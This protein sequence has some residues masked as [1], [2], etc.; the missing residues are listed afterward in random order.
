MGA[1]DEQAAKANSIHLP[2]EL[3]SLIDEIMA[4]RPGYSS[5]AEF[6]REVVREKCFSVIENSKPRKKGR[7]P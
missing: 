1:T 2:P 5:R 6:V 7:W 3:V 4:I